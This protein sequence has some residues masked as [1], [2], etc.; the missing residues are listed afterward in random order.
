MAKT[1]EQ[2]ILSIGAPSG[3][4]MMLAEIA[5]VYPSDVSGWIKGRLVSHR[6]GAAKALDEAMTKIEYAWQYNRD[7]VKHFGGLPLELNATT[8]NRL[9]ADR[10]TMA[11]VSRTLSTDDNPRAVSSG[12]SASI[13]A[14]Q[15]ALATE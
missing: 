15:V 12:R 13:K 9:Y 3:I 5:G 7:L 8:V 6:H 2:R 10:G 1:P 11:G 14:A 4:K